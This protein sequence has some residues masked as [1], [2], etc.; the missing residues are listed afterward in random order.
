MPRVNGYA[1]DFGGA[2]GAS[3]MSSMNQEREICRDLRID[4]TPYPAMTTMKMMT[5]ASCVGGRVP[6]CFQTRHAPSP[7]NTRKKKP[8]I[9]CHNEC[10]GFMAAGTTVLRKRPECLAIWPDWRAEGIQRRAS[11]PA[12][13]PSCCGFATPQCYQIR[14]Y[15]PQPA[16][17]HSI[18]RRVFGLYNQGDWKLQPTRQPMALNL[19]L[20]NRVAPEE[21]GRTWK[22]V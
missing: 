9:R 12:T 3:G 1:P 22:S 14:T 21:R 13:R 11:R 15:H 17:H 20:Y 6:G 2:P 18:V 10:T 4:E 19:H 5:I 7:A 16:P 8:R